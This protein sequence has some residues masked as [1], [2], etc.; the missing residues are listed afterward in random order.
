MKKFF[1]RPAVIAFLVFTG[2][3]ALALTAIFWGAW[4]LDKV[5][6]APDCATM[7]AANDMATWLKG[8]L[9][10][11]SFIPSDL[12]HLVGSMYFWVE[13]QFA[14][15]AW[16]AALGVAFYLRGRG[17]SPVAC[18]GG[19]SA[20][21]L[22]GYCFTLFS[23][24]HLGWF[25]WLM[26]GPFAF[27][28]VDRCVRKGKWRNW[29]LLGTILA[30]A[31]ARQPDLWLLFTVLTF[32]YGLWCLFRERRTLKARW[33]RHLA[34]VGV[35]IVSTLL[36]GIPQ[37]G[38]AIFH[39]IGAR[40]EQMGG[41]DGGAA[42]GAKTPEQNWLFCTSWSLPPEDT[43]EFAFAEI[44][45][46]SNDPRVSPKP[47]DQYKGRLGQ[48]AIVPQGTSGARD[49]VTGEILKPGDD[50]WM[51]Y[52]Q[53]SLYFGI[54]SLLLAVCGVV[55]WG[56]FRRKEGAESGL[57]EKNVVSF[58]DVPFWVGAGLLVYLCAL[59]GFTPFYRLVFA[60]PF[61]D[62]LR[63]PVKFVHLLEF[64]VAVLAGYG[65]E[66]LR[67]RVGK[68]QKWIVPA[69]SVLA[70]VNVVDLARVDAKY[71][72]TEDRSFVR[73]PNETAEDIVK[74]GGGVVALVR[75]PAWQGGTFGKDIREL[76]AEMPVSMGLHLADVYRGPE[77]IWMMVRPF[78]D[79][80]QNVKGPAGE[81]IFDAEKMVVV[82]EP[83]GNPQY[84]KVMFTEKGFEILPRICDMKRLIEGRVLGLAGLD[85]C[86]VSTNV[87]RFVLASVDG[88]TKI[89]ERSATFA[90]LKQ[91]GR[92]KEVAR[93]TV[94]R[95]NG[96]RRVTPETQGAYVLYER[97]DV[98]A[99][100]PEEVPTPNRSRQTFGFLSIFATFGV[101]LWTVIGSRMWNRKSMASA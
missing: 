28:L 88:Q 30:W 2:V 26:Y 17:L 37:F 80:L 100:A 59:G 6:I 13:L 45:G 29:A 95:E 5:P 35:V 73:A 3:Y 24:G 97:T 62:L 55:G 46:G 1:Q 61:G 41:G 91:D 98:P 12:M 78:L 4:S 23:A 31:S 71:L 101:L 36:V 64:C 11:D 56:V 81:Q 22:M 68:G 67:I 42:E 84:A 70:V 77:S 66:F 53:H 94:T 9:S 47:E 92:L 33:K 54:I 16:L 58:G 18:Y 27:G 83:T 40:K 8:V 85:G 21:G 60:L 75:P 63:A 19:G 96:I 50:Y 51:P 52:R 69:L 90:T 86:L 57:G 79:Q 76:N 15:A 10:G 65:I 89:L 74:A 99:P 39:D 48:H 7:F 72:A 14:L 93:Y 38:H 43:L 87:P 32:A 44:H 25:I 82:E 49:P 34:G 20:F